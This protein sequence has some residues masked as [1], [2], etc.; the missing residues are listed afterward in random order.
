MDNMMILRIGPEI[1]FFGPD[2][3]SQLG[4]YGLLMEKY[5]I[6]EISK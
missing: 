2:E 4:F 5:D 1:E 6:S 3:I